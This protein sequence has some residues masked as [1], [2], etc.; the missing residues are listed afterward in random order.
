MQ[1]PVSMSICCWLDIT[2]SEKNSLSLSRQMKTGML[3]L[4]IWRISLTCTCSRSSCTHVFTGTLTQILLMQTCTHASIDTHPV[5]T[6]NAHSS[7]H[8]HIPKRICAHSCMHA[9]SHTGFSVSHCSILANS[10]PEQKYATPRS[11]P[12]RFY[13]TLFE[14]VIEVFTLLD[15]CSVAIVP[16]IVQ[17]LS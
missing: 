12:F 1:L 17:C 14:L 8:K 2:Q 5:Q 13:K 9:H 10:F 3:Q 7:P 6:S 15:L 16:V 4:F 11:P